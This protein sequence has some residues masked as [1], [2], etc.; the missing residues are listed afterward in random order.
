MKSHKNKKIK[1]K[2]WK[3]HPNEIKINLFKNQDKDLYVIR[4]KF[5]TTS[6]TESSQN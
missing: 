2:V 5:K 6:Q 1:S 4:L 3:R